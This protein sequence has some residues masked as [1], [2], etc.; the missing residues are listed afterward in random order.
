MLHP[1]WRLPLFTG[2]EIKCGTDGDKYGRDP[3]GK[4]SRFPIL[5]RRTQSYPDHLC[6]G[7]DKY[8]LSARRFLAPS[9]YERA[10][11]RRLRFAPSGTVGEARSRAQRAP[12]EWNQADV[13]QSEILAFTEHVQKKVWPIDAIIRDGASTVP[14][15]VCPND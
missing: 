13:P 9:E 4:P 5:L 7:F 1:Q 8:A 11:S 6:C 2:D 14:E 3:F 15:L 10:G 12:A